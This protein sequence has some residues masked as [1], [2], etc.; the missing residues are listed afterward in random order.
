MIYEETKQLY[1]ENYNRP[2]FQV[3]GFILQSP[4]EIKEKYS[5]KDWYKNHNSAKKLDWSQQTKQTEEDW[6]E[7]IAYASFILH[8][9]YYEK[10]LF[11]CLLGNCWI[12]ENLEKVVKNQGVIKSLWRANWG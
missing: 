3:F 5:E 8:K 12:E 11:N 7:A 6:D 10:N 9:E 1:P 4:L 2:F